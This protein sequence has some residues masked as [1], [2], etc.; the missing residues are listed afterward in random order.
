MSQRIGYSGMAGPAI[1]ISVY[2]FSEFFSC[3]FLLNT[4]DVFGRT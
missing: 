4:E 3:C 1:V 2:F